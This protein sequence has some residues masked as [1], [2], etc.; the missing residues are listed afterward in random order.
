MHTHTPRY[1]NKEDGNDAGN[2]I[3]T[4]KNIIPGFIK[5]KRKG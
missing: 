5:L 4:P 3:E 2:N 1:T